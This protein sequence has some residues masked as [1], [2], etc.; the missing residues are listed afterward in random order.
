M[1]SNQSSEKLWGWWAMAHGGSVYVAYVF[2]LLIEEG[3]QAYSCGQDINRLLGG[4]SF[5]FF[6]SLLGTLQLFILRQ[7]LDINYSWSL[8]TG[9]S[10][11]FALFPIAVISLIANSELPEIAPYSIHILRMLIAGSICGSII[12]FMQWGILRK[13]VSNS[14][15]W[16]L[17]NII[18]Y[19]LGLGIF[20]WMIYPYSSFQ[21]FIH[22]VEMLKE[23]SILVMI[24]IAIL[25]PGVFTGSIVNSFEP[26]D[27][28]GV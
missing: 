12:G 10:V 22:R 6:A 17:L 11:I 3:C 2:W 27:N 4:F 28:N 5:I 21:D 13:K 8:V 19:S 7:V 15:K 18:G 25:L 23:N 9:L 1:I 14:G 24:F 20:G 16:I 26:I